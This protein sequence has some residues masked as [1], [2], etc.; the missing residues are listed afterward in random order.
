MRLAARAPP[1]AYLSIVVSCSCWRFAICIFTIG[2]LVLAS[3]F[4][5][6][7]QTQ[8]LARPLLC[9]RRFEFEQLGIRG[10]GDS[11]FLR[12]P[13]PVTA[14]QFINTWCILIMKIP[15][16]RGTKGVTSGY[17]CLS[18]YMCLGIRE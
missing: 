14:A 12:L 16:E 7:C 8:A 4:E 18:G 3:L 2:V 6:E 17:I 13:P 15:E 11:E 5:L 1:P 10:L 9:T